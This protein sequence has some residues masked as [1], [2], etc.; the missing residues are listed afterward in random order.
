MQTLIRPL[1]AADVVIGSTTQQHP[2]GTLG[3]TPD[4]RRFRYCEA[5]GTALVAG[6]LQQQVAIVANHQNIAVAAAAAIGAETVTV[7][8]GATLASVN[9]Y[10]EGF[11]VVNDQAGEGFTY[12]IKGHPAAAS[13]GSLTLTLDDSIRVALTTSSEVC[14]IANPYKDIVQHPTTPTGVAVG[15]PLF[16]MAIDNFG[17]IQ[18]HGVVSCLSD[19]APG[20]V[21]AALSPSNATAGALESGVIGQGV[22]GQ[23]LQTAVDTEYR[24]VFLTID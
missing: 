1:V 16:A 22:V 6:T 7:T 3:E 14:L 11:M 20:S 13:A 23:A 21:G 9:Q 10:A 24:A 4:G 8:L 17:W 18:T 19:A 2:L 12:K 5:G 15:V